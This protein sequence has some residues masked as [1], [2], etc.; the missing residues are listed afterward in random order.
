M[1]H[2]LKLE[3][4]KVKNYKPFIVMAILYLILLP[5]SLLVTKALPAEPAAFFGTQGFY[6]FPNVWKYLGYIG[7]W[8]G[9]FF[10]GFMG[11]LSI[12]MEFGN[13]TLRQNII[14]G[15]SRKEYFSA[16]VIFITAISLAATVHY[17][18]SG[19]VIGLVHADPFY[20][21]VYTQGLFNYIPRFFLMSFGY[22]A[23]GLFFGMLVRRTGFA[24]FIFLAYGVFLE[25][26]L[27]GLH[28]YYFESRTCLFYPVNA[29]EDLTPIPF[30]DIANDMIREMDFNPFL[31]SG[32]AM[33]TVSIYT[34]LFLFGAYRLMVKRDL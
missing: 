10:L 31:S 7:N 18:L 1:I 34:A 19:T 33:I 29:I 30:P 2:L 16:K 24:V 13:K 9:F 20:L 28:M 11:V 12:T 26:I 6:T 8:I 23:L 14:T 5:V 15:L 32:E 21:D 25:Q 3:F 17:F 27:R 4:L 22:M